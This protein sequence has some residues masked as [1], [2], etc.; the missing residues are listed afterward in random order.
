MSGYTRK[1]LREV[2]NAAPKFQMPSEMEARFARTPI[3]GETLGPEPVDAR[4]QLPHP[5]RAQARR[6]RRRST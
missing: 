6:A 5:L 3:E 1:N 4:S 2:E